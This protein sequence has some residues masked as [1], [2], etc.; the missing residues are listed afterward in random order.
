MLDHGGLV[1]GRVLRVGG[2]RGPRDYASLLV[3]PAA[4]SGTWEWW[5]I[6]QCWRAP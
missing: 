5:P 1:S 4:S 2:E 3:D 6:A